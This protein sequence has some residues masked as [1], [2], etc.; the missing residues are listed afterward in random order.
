MAIW[1]HGDEAVQLAMDRGEI[2]PASAA[3]LGRALE[4]ASLDNPFGVGDAVALE[5]ELASATLEQVRSSDTRLELDEIL[6]WGDSDEPRVVA[7]REMDEVSFGA[8]IDDLDN[9]MRRAEEVFRDPNADDAPEKLAAIS[10]DIESGA[11][12]PLALLLAPALD[13]VLERARLFSAKLEERRAQ[14]AALA[15]GERTPL[16]MADASIFY[17][18]G[19]ELLEALPDEDRAFLRQPL[20]RP[21]DHPDLDGFLQRAAP[22]LDQFLEGT[23][24]DRCRL[25]VAWP[26]ARPEHMF[27]AFAPGI[28][29][30]LRLLTR[31]G[32]RFPGAAVTMIGHLAGDEGIA[33][34]LIGQRGLRDL[35]VMT[36]WPAKDAPVH[37]ASAFQEAAAAL[38]KRDPCGLVAATAELREINAA[39]LS[40]LRAHRE[41]ADADLTLAD[42]AAG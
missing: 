35:A 13:R 25:V 21:A 8:A 33:A 6:G 10:A 39:R 15:S 16:E 4:S 30:G 5:R 24:R 9:V 19:V 41:E 28:R 42:L 26:E 12:G 40:P 3:A 36:S 37:L 32:D 38:S 22:A 11:A 7:V 18:R 20:T 2:D 27:P 17:R 31:A 29:D 1:Q 34:A 14:F 23:R